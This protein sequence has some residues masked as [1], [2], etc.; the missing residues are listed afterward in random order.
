MHHHGAKDDEEAAYEIGEC[1]RYI[2]SLYPEG[3]KLRPFMS[4]GG[5]TW[6]CSREVRRALRDDYFLFSG[7]AGV[8]RT[9][10]REER[11]GHRCIVI[12]QEAIEE[13]TWRQAA[14]HGV[15]EAWL[16]TDPEHYLE[17]LDYLAAHR[18]QIWTGTTGAV[19]KYTEERDA[20]ESVTLAHA[21]ETGFTL[22]IQCDESK[23]KTYGRPLAELYDEPLTVQVRVP[24]SWQHFRAVQG[25]GKPV[26]LDTL[27]VDGQRCARFDVR[28]NVAAATVSVS[29]YSQ[30]EV[31]KF[32]GG[33]PAAFSMQ[34]DDSMDCHALFA[35]PELNKR[36]LVGTFFINPGLER[37]TR[38]REVWEAVCPKF[39]HELAN[40]TMHHHGAK[41]DEEAVYE[42]SECSRYIWKLYPEGS[43]LRPFLSGGGVT[44]NCSREVRREVAAQHFLFFGFAG[45]G[46]TSVA[47]DRGNGR[48]V[49]L[50][51]KALE[52]GEWR[53]VGFHGVGDGWI[54]T[55][56]E[57]YLELLDYLA[58]QRDQIWVGTTGALY[59]YTQER[60]AV[61]SVT[62]ADA[63]EAGFALSIQCDESKVRTYDR[64]LAEL[65]DEPLTVQVSVPDS[66]QRFQVVQGEGEPVVL[67]TVEVDGRRVARFDVRP[68]VAAATVSVLE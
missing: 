5:T 59:K 2:W 39:G 60:D 30:P 10:S 20:V 8:G 41:D 66:W 52:A 21:S 62:L 3:S 15:G 58:A 34:F 7:S 48:C 57:H 24:D 53:Q 6:N 13:G 50:A 4:G 1:S 54:V 61:E 33:R 46:R 32:K 55:S 36:R 44:W 35:I 49:V 37:H 16:V 26:V 27:E 22:S 43:K 40:H 11:T 51:E 63:S 18:D 29:P 19:Y 38:H 68:N 12:A 65:Y 31:M 9:S 64:P 17:L 56:Q 25:K 45:P 42:I 23:V 14:F 47:E 67:E 28:P